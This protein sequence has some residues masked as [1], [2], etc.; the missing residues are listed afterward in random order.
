MT[1]RFGIMLPPR[2]IPETSGEAK[3]P[4][5][6][7]NYAHSVSHSE[8]CYSLAHNFLNDLLPFRIRIASAH[9]PHALAFNTMGNSIASSR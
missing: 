5:S 6:A 9:S 8:L 3:N 1:L 4:E 7:R 2:D